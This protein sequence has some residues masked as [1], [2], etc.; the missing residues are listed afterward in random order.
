MRRILIESARRK[1]AEN[2]G[3]GVND[4]EFQDSVH[5]LP[6]IDKKFFEVLEVE[7]PNLARVRVV[8]AIEKNR[9]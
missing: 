4:P 2:R 6:I 1:Q 9:N 8:Q 7:N 3:S 5:D